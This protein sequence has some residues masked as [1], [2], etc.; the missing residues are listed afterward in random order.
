M[1]APV[2]LLSGHEFL[3][4]EALARLRGEVD[5]DPLAESSF[6]AS[7]SAAD[8]VGALE[9]PSLLGGRRLVVVRSAHSLNKEQTEALSRYLAS[10]A[11][12]SVL[13]LI[14]SGRSKLAEIVKKVGAVVALDAPRGRRLVGWIRERARGHGMRIDDRAGWA[15]IDAVGGD[16]RDLDGALEQMSTGAAPGARIGAPEVRAFFPRLADERIY[17]FTDAV[18][19]RRLAEA[20]T[21]LRRLLEQGDEPLVI[22][23]AVTGQIRRLVLA[24]SV[25]DGGVRAVA[26]A[27]GLPE[28][29]AERLHRQARSYREEELASAM[30]ALSVADV[31]M[32]GGDLPA[33]IALERAVI[34][35]VA[36]A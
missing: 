12:H 2:V 36:R 34:D 35:I 17:A 25:A 19:D 31:D 24:R 10:P 1:T 30:E 9:T 13:V 18:G 15:L 6:D 8:I 32:K 21:A 29:R 27:L 33:E 23:G 26:E 11:P 7:A 28:W 5:A 14:A 20:M 16:L 4:E 3:T 22:L